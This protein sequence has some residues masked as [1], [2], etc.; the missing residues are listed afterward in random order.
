MSVGD[1]VK[2][3]AALWMEHLFSELLSQVWAMEADVV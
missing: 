3:Q 1:L 2:E